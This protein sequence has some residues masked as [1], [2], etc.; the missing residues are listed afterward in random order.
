MLVETNGIF[1]DLHPWFLFLS[2]AGLEVV[3]PLPQ[4]PKCCNYTHVLPHKV[5]PWFLKERTIL[6]L[7]LVH[8]LI[9]ILLGFE[10]RVSHLGRCSTTWAPLPV[11]VCFVCVC[12]CVCVCMC[13]CVCER[14]RERERERVGYFW[15]RILRAIYLGR[16]QTK[17][18]LISAS[19]VV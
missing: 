17:I 5:S 12:V 10:P 13:V 18:L 8:T 2:Q 9:L 19:W 6:Q 16:L 3:I 11:F 1:V 7:K 14:E 15:D 4:V